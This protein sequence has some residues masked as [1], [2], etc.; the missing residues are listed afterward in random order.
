MENYLEFL[1]SIRQSLFE[2]KSNNW[3]QEHS[4][5]NTLIEEMEWQNLSSYDK[6]ELRKSA[7]SMYKRWS[8]DSFSINNPQNK[9]N[10]EYP[11]SLLILY[12][13]ITGILNKMNN[14]ISS[15]DLNRLKALLI[16]EQKFFDEKILPARHVPLEMFKAIYDDINE[17]DFKN[18]LE[19]LIF[20]YEKMWTLWPQ[21]PYKPKT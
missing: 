18:D 9:Y 10:S 17:L 20:A 11:E 2:N 12:D 19:T 15:L 7:F 6:N 21:N 3:N 14:E 8:T 5:I 16:V 13:L 1:I 4:L